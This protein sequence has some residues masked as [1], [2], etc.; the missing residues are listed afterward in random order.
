VAR[1][2]HDLATGTV[3]APDTAAART[4][5]LQQVGRL[6]GLPPDLLISATPDQISTLI[7]RRLVAGIEGRCAAANY[8]ALIDRI[9][10]ETGRTVPL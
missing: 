4:Q 8:E 9:Q 2:V 10:V 3:T 5:S 6:A 7:R 1:F